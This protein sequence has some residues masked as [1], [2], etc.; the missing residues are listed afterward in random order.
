MDND[1]VDLPYN[2]DKRLAGHLEV[3]ALSNTL[4]KRRA[5][6]K[7]VTEETNNRQHKYNF[8]YLK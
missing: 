4:A 6:G 5:S 8:S 3:I 2:H 7:T 1:L